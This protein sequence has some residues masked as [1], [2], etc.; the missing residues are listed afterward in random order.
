VACVAAGIDARRGG[1]GTALREGRAVAAAAAARDERQVPAIK[2]H[3][4]RV[5]G[6]SFGIG[7]RPVGICKRCA[8]PSIEVETSVRHFGALA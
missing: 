5:R 3:M 6:A 4:S 2:A 7:A 1:I 8:C